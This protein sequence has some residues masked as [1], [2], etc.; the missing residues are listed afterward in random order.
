MQAHIGI[1]LKKYSSVYKIAL[2]DRLNGRID[3]VCSRGSFAVGAL[4]SYE[5][6]ERGGVQLLKGVS[7]IDMPMAIAQKDILFLHHV[8]E[9]CYYFVP[10]NSCDA[11]LFDLLHFLYDERPVWDQSLKIKFL[12]KLLVTLGVQA[13]HFLLRIDS[14]QRL[15]SVSVDSLV[16]EYVDLKYENEIISWVKHC[17]GQHPEI[18]SFKTIEF[19]NNGGG[20]H[21]QSNITV[22]TDI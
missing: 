17:I 21:E 13:E 20:D 5:L 2:F 19:L 9:I 3:G 1:V 14:L 8:L 12:F 6:Q 15:R 4:L 10:H 22:R 18:N 16:N 11:D 7:L